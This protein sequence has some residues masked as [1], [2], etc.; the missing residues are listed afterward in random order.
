MKILKSFVIIAGMA[1]ISFNVYAQERTPMD[2]QQMARK[3]TDNIKKN[4]TGITPDQESKILA[5]EQEFSQAMQDARNSSNGDREAMRSKMQPLKENRDAK[6][7]GILTSDQYAQY[8]KME[9]SHQ[10]GGGRRG[11]N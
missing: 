9:E 2:P 1:L 7:K 10:W 4:V 8:Q 11:G 3:Q 6:I 5:V